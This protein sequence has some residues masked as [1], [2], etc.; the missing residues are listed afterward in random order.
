MK[1]NSRTD[2]ARAVTVERDDGRH[3]ARVVM[4]STLL[5]FSFILLLQ[6]ISP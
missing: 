6:A 3:A 2:T 4:L 1:P 5:L